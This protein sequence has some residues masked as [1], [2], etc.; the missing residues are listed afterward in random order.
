VPILDRDGVDIHFA[1]HGDGP[2]TMLLSH[3]WGA[4]S[5]MFAGNLAPL[6]RRHRVITWDL[7][8]HG[9]SDYP[10]DP[11][12]YSTALAAGDMLGLLDE[13]GAERA[14]LAGHSLGGYLS[15]EVVLAHPERVEALVLVDT[16]PGFRNGD[17]RDRW[18][19]G[20]DRYAARLEE[21]GLAGLAA[22]PEQRVD[23]H[24]DATG[25]IHSA[26]GMLRQHDAH[27]LDGLPTIDVPTLV[28]VGGADEQFLPG[29]RYMAA[30]IPGARLVE[31]TGAGHAP[32][33]THAEAFD[34][35]LLDFLEPSEA[36]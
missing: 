34:R 33:I 30:K 28:V 9:R 3:G 31:I 1:V 4:S 6:A 16:G 25:L 14:V 20:A 8:G 35:H 7:R 19:A 11:S 10:A 17:A 15:L 24:R 27:V 21:H 29:A 36:P 22:G 12:R 13:V 32:N 23:E 5:T 18:N 2:R 26:R